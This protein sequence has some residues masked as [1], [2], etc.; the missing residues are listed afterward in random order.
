MVRNRC[1][2]DPDADTKQALR[3]QNLLLGERESA[4][5]GGKDS[6]FKPPQK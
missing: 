2:E 3:E 1:V 5:D 4:P 6:V